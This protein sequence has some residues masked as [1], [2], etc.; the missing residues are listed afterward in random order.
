MGAACSNSALRRYKNIKDR[1]NE[2]T[3][4]TFHAADG[5]LPKIT[6]TT[7]TPP[8]WLFG[9]DHSRNESE[10]LPQLERN[11]AMVTDLVQK[12]V[13]KCQSNNAAEVIII[14]ENAVISDYDPIRDP[15]SDPS[16][17][18]DLTRH[19]VLRTRDAMKRLSGNYINIRSVFMDVF[20]RV[21][22]AHGEVLP[23]PR[24][25]HETEQIV[26]FELVE[27]WV[28]C[29]KYSRSEALQVSDTLVR[30]CEPLA[31]DTI[32]RI[33][34]NEFYRGSRFEVHSA[35]FCASLAKVLIHS[36]RRGNLAL[37]R[38]DDLV[39]A[40]IDAN[41]HKMI[42]RNVFTLPDVV[43]RGVDEGKLTL[44]QAN[45]MMFNSLTFETLGLAGDAVLNEFITSSVP[46]DTLVVMHA[47]HYHVN[48]QR[49]WLLAGK[50]V[51]DYERVSD[52]ARQDSDFLSSRGLV[53]PF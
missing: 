16:R 18:D 26:R 1:L 4:L 32:R 30:A 47:G 10:T 52:L 35:V 39:I 33:T 31:D 53:V 24:T 3:C 17:S 34:V 12:A 13:S 11:C 5:L 29:G 44:R 37:R 45:H 28:T 6:T 20:G 15:N 21:R 38:A 41:I 23:R 22:L 48:N 19:S 40:D 36:R 27:F 42:T 51:S 46:N 25:P 7:G 14:Y 8:I 2:K 50:Y 49:K 9:E 43:R